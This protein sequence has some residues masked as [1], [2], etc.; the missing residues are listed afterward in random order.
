M[1]REKGGHTERKRGVGLAE[2]KKGRGEGDG[3][4]GTVEL[5]NEN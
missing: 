4:R 3:K 2:N 5:L 1:G